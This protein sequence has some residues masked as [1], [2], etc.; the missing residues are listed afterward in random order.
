MITELRTDLTIGDICRNFIYNEID[1]KGLYG[2]G[3]ML[4]IQPEYQRNYIYAERKLDVPVIE[5]V[6]S[7][8]PLGLL[9]FNKLDDEHY[10]VLDGQQRITSLG[11]FVTDKL[12]ILDEHGLPHKFSSFSQSWQQR[13]LSTQLII[14]ICE[15]N[16]NDE[17]LK[18]WFKIINKGGIVLNDQEL[19]NAIYSGSF[20]TLAK[21]EYSNRGNSNIQMWANFI[22]GSVNRQ[23]FLNAALKWI[24]NGKICEYMEAHRYD[25]NIEELKKY[26]NSVIH[27]IDS[28][29]Y[30]IDSEM[31]GLDWGRLYNL[32]HNKQYNY[33]KLNMRVNELLQ[34]DSIR[35][36]ANIYEYVLGGEKNHVL[37]EVRIFEEPTKKIVYNRQTE[38]AIKNGVS[39]CPLCALGNDNNHAR[40]YKLKE[41]DADHV[42]AWSN[43][44]TTS[45]DNCQMLCKTHNRIKGNK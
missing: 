18:S 6:I 33:D 17:E 38:Q 23:D 34:D 5:S 8:Y 45:I 35:K 15:C 20:V 14:Y 31:C 3:G 2:W 28:T 29:F 16:G 43:G 24:S 25:T 27:W 26:F 21:S 37:L 36:R 42:T 22:K 7:G 39:N 9:Y 12:S 10:E 44:G 30:N 41:M 32:Y 4:T 19:Y 11:R 40:I 13:F 1:G